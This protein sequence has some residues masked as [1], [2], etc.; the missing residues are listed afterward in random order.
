M[1]SIRK[2]RKIWPAVAILSCVASGSS[3]QAE[4][5]QPTA[6]RT[7][8]IVFNQEF[9]EDARDDL[10]CSLV[11]SQHAESSGLAVAFGDP[12]SVLS[13]VLNSIGHA[14][15][16]PTEQYFY[17]RFALDGKTVSGNVRF[18]DIDLGILHVGYF[19]AD[20]SERVNYRA[21]G[22]QDGL[23]VEVLSGEGSPP[24]SSS[25]YRVC[26]NG[27]D[28]VFC[29]PSKYRDAGREAPLRESEE[30]ICGI[31]D[32]SAHIFALIFNWDTKSFRYVLAPEYP[33]WE[34]LEPLAAD[35][36]SIVIGRESGYVFHKTENPVRLEL[37]AI[38]R[39]NIEANNYFDGCFDQVP[40]DLPLR[41]FL[42]Q[43]YPYTRALSPV[44][45]HGNFVNRKSQR[46]AISPYY[47]YRSLEELE[48]IYRNL[49]SRNLSSEEIVQVIT[50]EYQQ[51]FHA[52]FDHQP[53]SHGIPIDPGKSLTLSE[54]VDRHR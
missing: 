43:A 49:S 53:G 19:D 30:Y 8:G 17:Y 44:D 34:S 22:P 20:E 11:R 45:M 13:Y 31:F 28:A 51:D 18:T 15:V 32:E 35:L 29:L 12:A 38:F 2:L 52:K 14:T 4:S 6:G 24:C 37:I 7:S 26:F 25:N 50:R 54:I 27:Q 47:A 39:D 16:Y 9:I 3:L 46:V 5:P 21:F 41:P 23:A 33:I 40:P 36:P 42:H 10:Q 1:T 48:S